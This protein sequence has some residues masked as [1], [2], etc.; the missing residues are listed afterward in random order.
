MTLSVIEVAVREREE[1]ASKLAGLRGQLTDA[2][3]GAQAAL[4]SLDEMITEFSRSNSDVRP[5]GA[6][7][8]TAKPDPLTQP[9]THI[10]REKGRPMS[11]Q[12]ILGA[13][14]GKRM[15]GVTVD[16]IRRTLYSGY[17]V[18]M[19]YGKFAPKTT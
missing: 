16:K 12:E 5:N 3:R 4:K 6:T 1:T 10:M 17:F 18:R 8:S 19:T 9:I 11:A 14:R 7:K 2:V 15:R 13:L